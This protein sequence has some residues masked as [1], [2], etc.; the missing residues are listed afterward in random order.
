MQRVFL[1]PYSSSQFE[2]GWWCCCSTL[3]I[4]LVD[5]PVFWTCKRDVLAVGNNNRCPVIRCWRASWAYYKQAIRDKLLLLCYVRYVWCLE[6]SQND[7]LGL[8][9]NYMRW[10]SP[11]LCC[12]PGDFGI[13]RGWEPRRVHL[14]KLRHTWC[15]VQLSSPPGTLAHSWSY[16]AM[17]EGCIPLGK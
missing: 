15:V 9:A 1:V 12:K 14:G 5:C 13:P 6:W 4:N 8:K 7:G 3:A 16:C 10:L 11:K 17:R 2:V